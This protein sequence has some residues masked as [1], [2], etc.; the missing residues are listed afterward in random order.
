MCYLTNSEY[1]LGSRFLFLS[2][3]ITVIQNDLVS[4]EQGIDIKIK[5]PYTNLLK[6]MEERAIAERQQLKK[7]MTK[8]KLQVVR[9]EKTDTFSS[10][11]YIC[12]GREEKRNYFNPAIRTKVTKIIYELMTQALPHVKE[13]YR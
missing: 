2:M 8:Q 12:Q 11:L 10:Y 13:P 7:Y 1:T 9:L 3:A 5:E 4:L 6:T